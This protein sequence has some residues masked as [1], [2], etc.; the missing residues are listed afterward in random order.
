MGLI[1]LAN[2]IFSKRNGKG[3]YLVNCT[4][5]IDGNT[6]SAIGVLDTGCS[7]T[8]I[9][10]NFLYGDNYEQR[11][12]DEIK[13][14]LRNNIKFRHAFGIETDSKSYVEPTE[15]NKLLEDKTLRFPRILKDFSIGGFYLG[16]TKFDISYTIKNM[17]LIGNDI[18]SHMYCFVGPYQPFSKVSYFVAAKEDVVNISRIFKNT[19]A[20]LDKQI[21]TSDIYL[22]LV[23]EQALEANYLNSRIKE[24]K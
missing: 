22:D 2:Y 24:H 19:L 11:K 4:F 17:L 7:S 20:N 13:Y 16:D 10:A 9:S 21:S 18:L 6:K 15:L 1:T 8:L 5:E 14:Y 3:N 12:I 23:D